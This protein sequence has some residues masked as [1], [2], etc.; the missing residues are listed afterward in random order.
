MRKIDWD[1][2]L[3]DED[4]AFAR[5]AGFP[6]VEDRIAANEAR[7]GVAESSMVDSPS[8]DDEEGDDYEDWKVAELQAEV[9]ERINLGRSI[10][11]TGSGKDG[12]VLKPDLISAL[13]ADDEADTE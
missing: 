5:Q 4:K 9:D 11:V 1:A 3:S 7:F 13:R 8:T 2:A 12:N 10:E 6:L